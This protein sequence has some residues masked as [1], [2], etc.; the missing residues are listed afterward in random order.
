MRIMRSRSENCEQRDNERASWREKMNYDSIIEEDEGP[1]SPRSAEDEGAR[2]LIDKLTKTEG[3]DV[4]ADCGE[5][6]KL[7]INMQQRQLY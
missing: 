2:E 7:K 3:N 5:K 4:C 1:F 6:S